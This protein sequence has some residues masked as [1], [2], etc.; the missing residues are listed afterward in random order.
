M[1]GFGPFFS[2]LVMVDPFGNSTTLV[3]DADQL[4]VEAVTDAVGNSSTAV[5]DRITLS[6]SL[7]TDANGRY[8]CGPECAADL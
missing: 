3:Y 7:M 5:I 2:P 6:P 8:L 4:F 1:P